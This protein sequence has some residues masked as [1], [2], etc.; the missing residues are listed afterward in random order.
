MAVQA[1]CTCC[2]ATA[3]LSTTK[4][5]SIFVYSRALCHPD[6][7]CTTHHAAQHPSKSS[8]SNRGCETAAGCTQVSQVN[9]GSIT[10]WEYVLREGCIDGSKHSDLV[11]CG[12][13]GACQPIALQAQ[14]RL[15][16]SQQSWVCDSHT[17][18]P[19]LL[20]VRHTHTA[21]TE[22]MVCTQ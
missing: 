10:Y 21:P 20:L 14:S 3:R 9:R 22:K 12:V 11:G 16:S 1:S 2:R 8:I 7:T 6:G 4:A 5:E 19:A 15:I 18:T 13:E 17:P